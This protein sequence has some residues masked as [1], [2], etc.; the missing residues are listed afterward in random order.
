MQHSYIAMAL[1]KN[2]I[3]YIQSLKDKKNRLEYGTFVAEGAKMVF[4]L[5][6]SRFPCQLIAALPEIIAEHPEI[7]A[8]EIV[9]AD[10]NEL[11]KASFLK[12][13]PPIIGVFYI[14]QHDIST[15]RFDKKLSLVLDNI[16]DPGNMGTILRIADWFGI[17]HVVCSNDT[18][19]VYNPKTVQ[20]TMGA[21]A[22]VKTHYTD[23][24]DFLSKHRELPTYGAF[25]EGK[26]I[27]S[28][29]LSANG[30][31]VMGNEGKGISNEIEKMISEKLFIPNFP[32]ERATSESLNVAVA[33]AIICSEFRRRV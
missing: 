12:T 27:Y 20:A 3:K 10:E 26:N 9:S 17:E 19:D 15:T 11:K 24:S 4:D 33:T 21:I 16:Q 31:I 23:L 25:L 6:Q 7:A 5:L 8:D 13:A 30:F 32:A 2:K 29:P 14:P 18:V 1:S 22:R 28:E